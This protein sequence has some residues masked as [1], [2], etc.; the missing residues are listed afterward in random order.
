MGYGEGNAEP[1]RERFG[2][3]S[4]HSSEEDIDRLLASCADSDA[5][6]PGGEP[7]LDG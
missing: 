5:P 2:T 6:E 4:P 3:G 7:Q 1:I